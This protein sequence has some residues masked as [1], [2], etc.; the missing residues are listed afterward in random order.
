M[1]EHTESKPQTPPRPVGA[2]TRRRPGV[3]PDG[4]ERDEL[5]RQVPHRLNA[6]GL[7]HAVPGL[8]AQFELLDSGRWRR[9]QGAARIKCPCKG[10]AQLPPSKRPSAEP[11][12]LLACEDCDRVY[13]F[14]GREVRVAMAAPREQRVAA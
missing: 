12:R 6:V 5:N 1:T 13:L 3:D 8:L 2:L 11:G 9:Y 7:A 10:E 4:R 14:T